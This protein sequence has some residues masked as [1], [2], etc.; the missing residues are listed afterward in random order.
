MSMKLD[1]ILQDFQEFLDKNSNY[2]LVRKNDDLIKL[3]GDILWID[4]DE[5]G[6]FMSRHT[7]PAI[8]RSLLLSPFNAAFTWQTTLVTEIMEHT[9]KYTHFKTQNSEYELFKL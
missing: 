7:E 3:S 2:K 4:F 8:G 5:N 1:D 9:D 6:G